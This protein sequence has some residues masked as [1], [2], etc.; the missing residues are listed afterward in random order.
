MRPASPGRMRFD[1]VSPGI[2]SRA[3]DDRM[4]RMAGRSLVAQVRQRGA[5]EAQRRSAACP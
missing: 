2:G 5:D 1:V 4:T 3:D